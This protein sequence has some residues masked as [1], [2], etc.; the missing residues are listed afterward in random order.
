MNPLLDYTG[1][2]RFQDFK[3]ELVAPAVDTLL[4][5]CRATVSRLTQAQ[6]PVTWEQFVQPL[7][8]A[9]ERL[10]RTWGQIAHLNAVVNTLRASA[11]AA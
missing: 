7:I 8:D 6:T 11:P 9:N 2:P 10:G 3:P 1:L 5:E 4:A